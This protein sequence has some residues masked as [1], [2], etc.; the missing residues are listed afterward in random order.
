[1]LEVTKRT[2]SLNVVLQTGAAS[3]NRLGNHSADIFSQP[4][5]KF[6]ILDN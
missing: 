2:I 3:C 6:R 4:V 5:K 1:M